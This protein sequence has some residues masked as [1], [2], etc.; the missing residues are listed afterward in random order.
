[1]NTEQLD[2]VYQMVLAAWPA[3]KATPATF[4]LAE[5]LLLPLDAV[6]VAAAIEQLSLEGREFAPTMGQ[7]AR[8]AHEVLAEVNG[9]TV[10]DGQQALAEVYDQIARVGRYG[11]PTWSHPAIGATVGAM[12]GWAATCGDDNREAFRAHFLRMYETMRGRLER[13]ALVAPSMREL[14]DAGPKRLDAALAALD[15]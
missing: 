7:V 4:V 2:F 1:M 6:A 3:S 5:R 14:L 8:R 12:G 10:P 11:D 15:P 13:E 9:T